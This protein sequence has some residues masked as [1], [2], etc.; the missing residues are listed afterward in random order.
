VRGRCVC[1]YVLLWRLALTLSWI[2]IL[3]TPPHK[4]MSRLRS[5]RVF[6]LCGMLL[7][8]LVPRYRIFSSPLF[9]L[10]VFFFF[11]NASLIPSPR[12]SNISPVPYASLL[13]GCQCYLRVFFSILYPGRFHP[14]RTGEEPEGWVRCRMPLFP[15]HADFGL[16]RG[17]RSFSWTPASFLQPQY[18][19]SLAFIFPHPWSFLGLECPPRFPSRNLCSLPFS[20]ASLR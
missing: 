7:Y 4:G 14:T 15:P 12:D 1:F 18:L 3:S 8:L 20:A 2:G 10:F 16:C 9:K 19:L 5:A 13:F 17:V 6:S 11:E